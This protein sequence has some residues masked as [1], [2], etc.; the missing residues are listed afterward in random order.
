LRS[1]FIQAFIAMLL[2]W[3][4]FELFGLPYPAL[5]ATLAALCTLIPWAGTVLATVVVFGLGSPAIANPLGSIVNLQ[6]W[7][8]LVYMVAV[9][10]FLEF[11]V[12]PRLFRRNRYNSLFT[13]LTTVALTLALGVGGLILGPLVGYVIQIV[14][15]LIYPRLIY[16]PAV[17]ETL[18]EISE[19]LEQLR[20]RAESNQETPPE[21]Q[22]LLERLT[23]IVESQRLAQAVDE[24]EPQELATE[25][26]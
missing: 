21:V 11:I 14:A 4:G 6:G 24:P 18:P 3:I 9:L 5:T 8:A 16:Q 17:P 1:E 20:F 15:R 13:A 10:C 26:G 12:E 2:L 23:K 25:Q 22:S 7:L 19:R